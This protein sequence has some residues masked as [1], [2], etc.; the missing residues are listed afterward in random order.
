MNPVEFFIQPFVQF[1][2]MRRALLSSLA[3]AMGC[4]PLGCFFIVRRMSLVGDALSHG[5]FPGVALA[6][7]GFGFSVA[8]MSIGGVLTGFLFGLI[9]FGVTYKTRLEADNT[10]AVLFLTALALGLFIL[11][12]AGG[13]MD[14]MHILMGN[15]LVLSTESLLWIGVI[16]TI[17]LVSLALFYR[18]FVLHAFDPTFFRAVGGKPFVMEI[19]GLLLLTLNLVAAF[20]ALGTLLALGL[21]LLPGI[22]A[23]LYVRQFWL[24]VGLASLLAFG[25]SYMGLCLS[26]HFG[27]PTG[28]LIILLLGMTYVCAVIRQY[29]SSLWRWGALALMGSFFF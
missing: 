4:S 19:L 2:F 6:F 10:F 5:L 17:T 9:S 22:V 26:Y 8:A 16:S 24:V 23:R 14:I 29:V 12:V 25:A 18:S 13:Y 11:S 28:P 1:D 20:Q 27:W 15:L 21:L 7:L 3:L